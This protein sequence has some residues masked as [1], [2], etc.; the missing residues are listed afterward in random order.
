[1]PFHSMVAADQT[2][3]PCMSHRHSKGTAHSNASQVSL[4]A[5]HPGCCILCL[6]FAM[7]RLAPFIEDLME[8]GAALS[9]AAAMLWL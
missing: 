8:L 2:L 9:P 3:V 1:M 7:R 5:A 6:A 4:L